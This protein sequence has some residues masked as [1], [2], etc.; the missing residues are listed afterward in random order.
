TT[1][2]AAR[3][4]RGG[5]F[6]REVST[7]RDRIGAD[8][9][10]FPAE[11]GRY[12]LFVNA[13][14]PWAWRTILYRALK[15]LDGVIGISFTEPGAGP[16]GWTF[17]AEPEP[18]LGARHMHDVYRAAD[19][20]F[21]GRCTVPVLWDLHAGTIVNNES[22][23]IIRMLDAA[24]DHLPG[25]RPERYY[26]AERAAEIDALNA[27]IYEK[28]NN[29]VYR[30]GFA[31][32]Q[33]AYDEAFDVLFG[34]LDALDARLAERRYLCGDAITEADWRLFSTLVR[35]DV[36]YH[37]AF[38]CNRQRLVD[39]PNLWPYTRDLYAQPGVAEVVDIDAIKGI[40]YGSRPPGILPKGPEIDWRAPHGREGLV[41]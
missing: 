30:C 12:H 3:T 20:E 26:P 37:G 31:R 1:E 14:C 11:A 29:G 32:S 7:F 19:P 2:D 27:E 9:G 18:I 16:E 28:V 10:R 35:F 33:R 25:V 4:D 36:G 41:A 23:E 22:A 13:G 17:G 24:F 34:A 40:Y 8:D 6:E 39:F 21:T 5:A 15:G 38:R